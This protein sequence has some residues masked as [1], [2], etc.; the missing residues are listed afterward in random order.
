MLLGLLLPL[1]WNANLALSLH[2]KNQCQSAI[3]VLLPSRV[4]FFKVDTSMANFLKVSKRIGNIWSRHGWRMFGPLLF[5]NI[6][7]HGKRLLSKDLREQGRSSVDD[8]PGVET[9]R[10]VSLSA[11]GTINDN[12]KGAQPYQPISEAAFNT[13]IQTLPFQ[14]AELAFVDLGSGKGRAL[15]LAARAGFKSVVG[16]EFSEELHQ[17]ATR[18]IAAAHGHVPH[19]EKIQLIHGDAVAYEPPHEAVVLYLYNP[20]DASVM[21]PVI[22]KWCKSMQQHSHAVWVIYVNPME[23][24][25]FADSPGFKLFSWSAGVAVFCR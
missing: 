23:Q 10:S 17:A 14:P 4:L 3:Y 11:L 18:N 6:S 8:I 19:V 16:V 20:F 2:P 1:N 5:R 25:L 9:H 7:Y 15:L 12:S 21:K 22:D 24:A 13:I